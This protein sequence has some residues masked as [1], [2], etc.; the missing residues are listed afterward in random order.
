MQIDPDHAAAA[1]I[2][3]LEERIQALKEIVD[4]REKFAAASAVA[5]NRAL[6]VALD[7]QRRVN[8]GQNEFRGQSK[9]FARDLVDRVEGRVSAL[10]RG[11]SGGVGRSGGLESAK[12]DLF[13]LLGWLV[14]LLSLIL[15]WKK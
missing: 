9:D 14:A 12:S 15:L 5:A 13:R 8:E 1:G 6:D 10:E 3:R 2:A 4:E 11:A 7:A